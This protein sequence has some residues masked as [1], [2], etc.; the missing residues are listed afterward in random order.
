MA[1]VTEYAFSDS[2]PTEDSIGSADL[3]FTGSP[4]LPG[5]GHTGGGLLTDENGYA[6]NLVGS[7]P[8]VSGLTLMGWYKKSAIS[9]FSK[10][11]IKG[12]NWAIYVNANASRLIVRD[13]GLTNTSFS[14]VVPSDVNWHHFSVAFLAGGSDVDVFVFI[15]GVFAGTNTFVGTTVPD[16]T[17]GFD[18]GGYD[19]DL[20]PGA[21][22][23]TQDDVRVFS[24]A[25]TNASVITDWRNTPGGAATPPD[26]AT[27]AL[28][29]LTDLEV[30]WLRQESGITGPASLSDL[31]MAVY[32]ENERAYWAASSGLSYGSL[33]DHKYA[34]MKAATGATEGSLAD[35]SRIFFATGV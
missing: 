26:P 18:I 13:Y 24:E 8:P 31:R 30:R 10:S 1:L 25:I 9:G 23:L 5:G 16:V 19:P 20:T 11:L 12:S 6:T 4:A 2:A 29:S 3:T 34:A 22:S 15:D 14:V 21:G 7:P 35:V 27:Y 17:F 28:L 33:A 32:G